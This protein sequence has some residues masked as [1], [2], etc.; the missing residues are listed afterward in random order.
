MHLHVHLQLA[1]GDLVTEQAPKAIVS[2]H[3]F[4]PVYEGERRDFEVGVLSSHDERLAIK[5]LEAF[6]RNGFPARLNEPWSGKDG[7]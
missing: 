1:F 2:I 4:N 5:T 7:V 6:H 3:S